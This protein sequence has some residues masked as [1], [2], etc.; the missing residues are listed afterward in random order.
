MGVVPSNLA[1]AGIKD[2]VLFVAPTR[3]HGPVLRDA[4]ASGV[5]Y[6]Y[7][8]LA[9]DG[10][11]TR[12]EQYVHDDD[13]CDANHDLRHGAE[14]LGGHYPV[15]GGHERFPSGANDAFAKSI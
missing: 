8:F 4:T 3:S 14:L 12:K 15:L 5:V 7:F 1:L 10:F 13:L 6:L 9:V 11:S 2:G